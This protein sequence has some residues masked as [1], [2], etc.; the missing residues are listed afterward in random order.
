MKAKVDSIIINFPTNLGDT[1][2]A[3]P[4]LDKIKSNYPDAKITA[5]ASKR[6]ER[7]LSS[8]TFID[9]VVIFDKNWD[10]KR[11]YSFVLELRGKYQMMVDLKH[12]LLPILLKAKYRTPLIRKFSKTEH[13][14]DKY[15]RLIERIAPK[16]ACEKSQFKLAK[17]KKTHWDNLNVENAVFVACASLS[18]IKKYPYK[19][20]KTVVESVVADK[21]VFIL[22]TEE[23]KKVYQDILTMPGI[24][25]LTGQTTLMDIYHLFKKYAKAVIAVDSCLMH[26]A[27]YADIP[28]I[29]LFGP[30]PPERSLPKSR[31][32]II[33]QNKKAKCIP[34]DVA[35]C[36]NDKECMD[37]PAKDVVAAVKKILKN[38]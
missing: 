18:L 3:L 35:K 17:D 16:P 28:V 31:G 37:I 14:T 15:L 20:L 10:V 25:D 5:I 6:T 1:I 30:T 4:V 21:P 2:L 24:I 23:E 29:A 19:N 12:T 38:E 22:G 33:L 13:I 26:L 27:S 8:N 34:C 32:S 36:A 9:K 7:L 11:K